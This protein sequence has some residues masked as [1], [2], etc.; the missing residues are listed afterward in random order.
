MQ[1]T[2]T[3]ITDGTL[4]DDCISVLLCVDTGEVG[5][6]YHDDG[7]WQWTGTNDQIFPARMG[8]WAHLPEG[9]KP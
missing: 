2:I 8:A 4:P 5:E 3:W 6:A 9:P 1:E 7:C